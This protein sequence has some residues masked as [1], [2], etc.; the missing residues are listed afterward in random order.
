MAAAE[1]K[2][3]SSV[4]DDAATNSAETNAD[5][6]PRVPERPRCAGTSKNGRPC[7]RVVLSHELDGKLYCN[8]HAPAGAVLVKW[9]PTRMPLCEGVLADGHSRCT[10]AVLEH[11]TVGPGVERGLCR[12]HLDNWATRQTLILPKAPKKRRMPAFVVGEEIVEE[13]PVVEHEP[14]APRDRPSDLR[15]ALQT[16]AEDAYAEIEIGL[17]EA[18]RSA[19]KLT[20]ASC[21]SC[22][23][24][25]S[26]QVRDWNAVIRASSELLDR[27]VSKPQTAP[28]PVVDPDMP[29]TKEE[30]DRLSQEELLRLIVSVQ[31]TTA[32]TAM[33]QAERY[34]HLFTEIGETKDVLARHSEGHDVSHT[35][36]RRA[37]IRAKYW[38]E[39]CEMLSVFVGISLPMEVP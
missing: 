1:P 2:P 18:I 39:L 20:R 17:R 38:A 12:K 6:T 33:T 22:K 27:V 14:L 8:S 31:S 23:H 28:A 4:D 3:D 16:T 37:T 5:G 34:G 30:I 26:L 11:V 10:R 32:P 35:E 36:L 13:T 19:S 25:F 29:L 7:M 24:V 21:P 15:Q 9:D